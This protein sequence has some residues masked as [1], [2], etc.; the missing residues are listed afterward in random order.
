M[1]HPSLSFLNKTTV[2]PRILAD[3]PAEPATVLSP[4]KFD[5][6][7]VVEMLHHFCSLAMPG[8]SLKA[9]T[10]VFVFF[11]VATASATACRFVTRG[12]HEPQP[13]RPK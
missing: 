5:K 10:R 3:P 8:S 4:P 13:A 6:E 1:L 2:F 11:S 7:T 9:A 12:S